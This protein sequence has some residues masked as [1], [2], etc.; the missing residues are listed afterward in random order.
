MRID[1]NLNIVIPVD[2]T[3]GVHMFVHSTPVSA[4]VYTTYF[5]T[6]LGAANRL[7][8]G[9]VGPRGAHL[10]LAKVAKE[11]GEWD[12]P[13]G[14]QQG[15]VAEI[16][17]LTNVCAPGPGGWQMV[18]FDEAVKRGT[19]DAEDAGEVEAAATFFTLGYHAFPRG[20]RKEMIELAMPMWG[21]R[22]E[23]LPCSEFLRS[24]PT[25]IG[26]GSTGAKA[27]A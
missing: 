24:L 19:L 6:I 27:A 14:V 7:Y 16:R 15:L 12:T 25:L 5:D 13:G 4:D 11:K 18:P 26:D 22:T 23:S 20:A 10:M 17:R 21:A 1:K 9:G 8:A 2:S 3:A